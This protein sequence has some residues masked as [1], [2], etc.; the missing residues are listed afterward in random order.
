MNIRQNKNGRGCRVK[1]NNSFLLH[2]AMLD[3][4]S[5]GEKCFIDFV[6]TKTYKDKKR[7]SKRSVTDWN[8]S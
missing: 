4:S 5:N 8:I 2:I 7:R 1:N 3:F 6:R